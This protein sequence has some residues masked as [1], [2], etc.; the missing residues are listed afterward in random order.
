MI[1]GAAMR[2]RGGLGGA[3]GLAAVL[4]VVTARAE[5]A[6]RIVATIDGEPITAHELQQYAKDRDTAGAGSRQVLEALITDKLLEREIKALGIVARD[7]EIDR[8][9]HEVQAR[10]G[11]D[12]ARFQQAIKS[13]GMSWEAYR[14]KVKGEIEKAQLVN[15]E[16]RQHVNVSPEEI[17]RYYA[18]HL[19][20]YAIAE[21][22]RVRD[23]F[24]SA[25]S[26]EDDALE[27][28][29]AK[30]EEVRKLALSGRDF[31]TLARQ[32]SEGP[33]ADKGGELGTFSRGEME[34]GLEEVLFRLKPGEISEPVRSGSGF[35]L[36][37]VD[38]RIAGGHKP[39]DEVKEDIREALYNEALEARF[40]QW[41]SRDLRERHHVE[42]LD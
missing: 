35:H 30:A 5:I 14:A 42:V 31:A 40:Q 17:R 7:D 12:D 8:Y 38:E 36:L 15:R 25:D 16:I 28:A 2:A 11:M 20:D 3:V 18:Q 9:I 29:R 24:I 13:Q 37:R 33:G 21:R 19:D 4:W 10:T 23:I 32:Y 22:I 39:L 27:H 26:S 34:G 1:R 41:L 6:N